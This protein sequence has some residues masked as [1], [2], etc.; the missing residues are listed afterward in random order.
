M[1]R[2]IDADYYV[3]VDADDT[4]FPE[5]VHTLLAAVTSG[6]ADMAVGDR[7]SS[8]AYQRENKRKFHQFGNK[9][10]T[11]LIN[12][13]F[14]SKLNDILSGY[15]V[16]NRFFVKSIPI[17]CEGFEIETHLTLYT[18]SNRLKIKEFSVQ[19]KDRPTGSES[20]LHTYRDGIRILKTIFKVFKNYQPLF[21]FSSLALIFAV[22]GLLVGIQPIYEYIMYSYVH[23]VPSAV[24]AASLEILAM[25]T[26]FCGVILDTTIALHKE[27]HE[28]M[29]NLLIQINEK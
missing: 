9:L 22:V 25:L 5:D 17:V 2:S 11:D 29:M 27:R 10:V 15:R 13:I 24:L 16:F 18:L 7:H 23:K 3:M 6:E 4:Y 20:K 28:T 8:K 19:Y 26:L 14:S 21:F 12:R 1:F